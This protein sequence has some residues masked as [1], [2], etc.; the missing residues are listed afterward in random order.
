MSRW[1]V[2]EDI[3]QLENLRGLN[4]YDK[5]RI[6]MEL[7]GKKVI[8]VGAGK[9]GIAAAA[10]LKAN[11]ADPVIFDEN[12]S[13]DEEKVHGKLISAMTRYALLNIKP[14]PDAKYA[15]SRDIAKK[16][17]AYAMKAAGE[18]VIKKDNLSDMDLEGAEMVVMSP[19]VPLDTPLVDRFRNRGMYIS[20][21][22][23]LA[24]SCS[25][26]R[27]IA[28]TGTNGKTTTTALTGQIVKDY[29][30]GAKIV[31]L[32]AGDHP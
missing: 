9:S 1:K 19:G 30:G 4:S 2:N 18:I 29:Y 27:L 22:I 5:R 20:G 6:I 10:M 21:E 8:V 13:L 31:K 3:E 15:T 11:G 32:P 17:T 12:S 25:K 26:G 7:K 28:I 23:E 16:S 24:Y 14:G